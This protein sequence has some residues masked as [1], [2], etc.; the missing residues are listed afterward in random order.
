M[1]TKVAV[2]LWLFSVLTIG[3]MSLPGAPE[4]TQNAN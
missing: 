2:Q 1:A 3:A 4:K